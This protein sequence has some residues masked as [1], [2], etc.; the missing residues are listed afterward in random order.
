MAARYQSP[1]GW[2]AP[3]S[4]W[5]PPQGWTPDPRWGPAPDGW[6]FWVDDDGRPAG[7]DPHPHLRVTAPPAEVAA[8]GGSR[9]FI[10]YRRSDALA[11]AN[12]IHDGLASRL[13]TASI[14]M[15]LDSIPAGVDF[16]ALIRREI[17]RCDVVLVVIGDSWLEADP[18]T[19]HRRLDDEDDFVRLEIDSALAN[20]GV[21][22]IPL[23]VEGARMPA[24]SELPTS[25]RR[26]ARI[27]AM[28]LSDQ[29]WRTDVSRL[30]E[31][32]GEIGA[33]EPE[34]SPRAP[35]RPDLQPRAA[36]PGPLPAMPVAAAAAT[37]PPPEPV[38]TPRYPAPQQPPPSPS[39]STASMPAGPRPDAVPAYGAVSHPTAT[40]APGRPGMTVPQ[41][42]GSIGLTLL[43]VV[44]FGML[45]FV[46]PLV[47]GFARVTRRAQR[48]TLFVV[49]GVLLALIVA[50][51]VMFGVAPRD[52]GG[53]SYGWQTDVG[54]GCLFL[55]VAGGVTV[56]IVCWRPRRAAADR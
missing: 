24:S 5:V 33:A 6:R 38:S 29:R 46:T 49:A 8:D 3:P 14:F 36:A 39:F 28:E 40:Q 45:A 27:N 13:P 26:L 56:G 21:V 16:E 10:S 47:A 55:A 51:F 11:H 18:T 1:P 30:V 17:D 50:C 43:P 32:I 35:Q 9:I 7:S 53:S 19:G 31:R 41:V 48:I 54:V 2:P 4:G 22:V 20:D 44:S 52:S 25:I 37:S 42:L 12:G 34:P 15:D 23:L